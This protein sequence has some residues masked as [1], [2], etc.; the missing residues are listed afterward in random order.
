MKLSDLAWNKSYS[1]Y[2]AFIYHPFNQ[3]LMS[4][5]LPMSKFS[6][7]MEQD[8]YYIRNEARVE[9]DIVSLINEEYMDD[10]LGYSFDSL[11]YLKTVDYFFEITN[12]TKIGNLTAAS[13]DYSNHILSRNSFE[14]SV[15]AILPCFW[16]YSEAGV[17][18]ADNMSD[19]NPYAQWIDSYSSEEFSKKTN[20]LIDIFDYLADHSTPNMRE[21]MVDAFYKSAIKEVIFYND[22]YDMRYYDDAYL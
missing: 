17:Y 6:Y 3:D 13:I 8:S 22:I 5:T 14:E 12:S 19:N 15:A 7:Y 2:K 9:G 16:F 20:K 4:G 1:V 10:F 18:M 11:L 21:A